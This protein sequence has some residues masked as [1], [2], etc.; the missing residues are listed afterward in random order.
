MQFSLPN[1]ASPKV[2]LETAVMSAVRLTNMYADELG[3]GL[4][5]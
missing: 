2:F 3:Q 4:D 5:E 1:K